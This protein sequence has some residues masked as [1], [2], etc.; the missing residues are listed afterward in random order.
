MFDWCERTV[1]SRLHGHGQEIQGI[2]FLPPNARDKTNSAR[3][4]Y[5]N[6]CHEA[7]ENRRKKKMDIDRMATNGDSYVVPLVTEEGITIY[8]P[9]Q[10]RVIKKASVHIGEYDVSENLRA[11]HQE[12]GRRCR[13]KTSHEVCKRS[14]ASRHIV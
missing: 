2:N 12:D 7:M 3:Q 5:L 14:S 1:V 9:E 11:L 4:K 13:C 8:T 10:L 6:D